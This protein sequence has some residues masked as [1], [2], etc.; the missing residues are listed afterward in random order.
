MK[1]RRHFKTGDILRIDYGLNRPLDIEV[2]GC[3]D[4]IFGQKVFWRDIEGRIWDS[5][6]Y[7]RHLK[8]LIIK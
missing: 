7:S 2:V 8:N 4:T 6:H 1:K 3:R 5:Y